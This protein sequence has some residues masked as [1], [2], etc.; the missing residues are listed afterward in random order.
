MFMAVKEEWRLPMAKCCE[1]TFLY[2]NEGLIK[3][4]DVKINY[5]SIYFSTRYVEK[6]STKYLYCKKITKIWLE[7][8][9]LHILFTSLT[10]SGQNF[11]VENTSYIF[12]LPKKLKTTKHSYLYCSGRKYFNVC[13]LLMHTTCIRY[14]C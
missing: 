2:K 3:Y 5:W 4:S 8:V 13:S 7:K 14:Y 6:S 9:D 12:L 10:A 11:I 1:F